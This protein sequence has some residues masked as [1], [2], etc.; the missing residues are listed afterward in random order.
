MTPSRSIAV[1]ILLVV[2]AMAC[3]QIG[4]SLAKSL[5]PAVG[6]LGAA[7]LRL[8]LSAIILMLI[9]RPW[10]AGWPRPGKRRQLLLYGLALGGMNTLIYQAMDRIPLG[11]AVAL[12]FTGPVALALLSS[13]RLADLM[14]IA[15]MLA[16]L[17]LLFAP[18]ERLGHLDAVGVLFALGAG[19]CWALYIYYGRQAG[20][21]YGAN[22][23]AL[24]MLIA[25]AL[26]LPLGLWHRGPALFDP[27]WL[28]LAALVAVLSSALPYLFEMHAMTR[29]PA[30][31]FSILM[32]LEPALGT[33][34]G[35]ILLGEHLRLAQWLGIMAV[36]IAAAGSTL[37]ATRGAKV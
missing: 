29:M 26:S 6:P 7:T 10:R 27:R 13:R 24:G 28:P 20:L 17:T 1:P 5:F 21:Q 16:G 35:L 37:A 30:R 4:A 34:S 25:A 19:A 9:L 8:L 3:V 15:V 22:T 31:L 33:L 11:I 36:V 23:V 32:S 2:I 18:N 12:E 14:W